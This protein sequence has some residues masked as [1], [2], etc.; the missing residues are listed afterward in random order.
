MSGDIVSP[1]FLTSAGLCLPN[2]LLSVVYRLQKHLYSFSQHLLRMKGN[3][4]TQQLQ[5]KN[6]QSL[7]DK[8]CEKMNFFMYLCAKWGMRMIHYIGF[9]SVCLSAHRIT[10]CWFIQY[11]KKSLRQFLFPKLFTNG[12]L[13]SV[14]NW[15]EFGSHRFSRHHKH[16][17]DHN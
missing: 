6:L 13:N 4:I 12:H 2:W 17:F 15:L 16:D 10:I 14:I 1:F 7:E 9:P 3:E 8:L 5:K 11:L